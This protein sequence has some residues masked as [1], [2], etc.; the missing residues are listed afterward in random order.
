MHSDIVTPTEAVREFERFAGRKA[1]ERPQAAGQSSPDL[2]RTAEVCGAL[3]HAAHI[4][5]AIT[6]RDV[7][8]ALDVTG[9]GNRDAMGRAR[10]IELFGGDK[11]TAIGR[12]A[13]P[14]PLYGVTGDA[15][16]AL[17]VAVAVS[18]GWGEEISFRYTEDRA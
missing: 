10:L 11:E 13:S 12:K 5:T 4:A 1:I 15:W 6:R 18:E 14:G 16:A 7:L 2:L 8:R 9:K 17:A 3:A